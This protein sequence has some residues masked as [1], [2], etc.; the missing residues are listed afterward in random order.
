MVCSKRGIQDPIGLSEHR[1]VLDGVMQTDRE[2][3]HIT[4]MSGLGETPSGALREQSAPQC[5][6]PAVS[7]RAQ[8]RRGEDRGNNNGTDRT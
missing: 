3:L 2:R 7:H 4:R 8:G 1:P 5:A 6:V